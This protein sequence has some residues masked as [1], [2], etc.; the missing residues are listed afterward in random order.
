LP[1]LAAAEFRVSDLYGR[2]LKKS[3]S[4]TTKAADQ[5]SSD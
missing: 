5:L 4:M 2:I 3:K 1:F